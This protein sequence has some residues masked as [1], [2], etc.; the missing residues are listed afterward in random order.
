MTRIFCFDVQSQ[1]FIIEQESSEGN[2]KHQ[3]ITQNCGD[4][5][6]GKQPESYN[7]LLLGNG[8]EAAVPETRVFS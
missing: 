1:G 2:K 3:N 5:P 6:W 7:K 8:T 4:K